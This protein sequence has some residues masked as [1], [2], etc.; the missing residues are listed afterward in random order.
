MLELPVTIRL[1]RRGEMRHR[2]DLDEL[3]EKR[4]EALIVQGYDLKDNKTPQLP[5]DFYAAINVH[6][7]R[8]WDVFIALSEAFPDSLHAVYGMNE[9]DTVTTG[10]LSKHEVIS[11][12][13]ECKTELTQDGHLSFGLL[14]HSSTALLELTVTESKYI[15]FWG[16]DKA[17]FLTCM[18]GF[19]I[20]QRPRLEFVD[21]YPKVVEPLNKFIP[22]ARKPGEVIKKLNSAFGMAQ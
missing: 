21:E 6:N 10:I 17:A 5:H 15:R 18:A 4:K 1:P 2:T 7:S 22:N 14:H 19:S 12:F 13:S 8:L 3:M 9:P 20:P 16:K 11:R